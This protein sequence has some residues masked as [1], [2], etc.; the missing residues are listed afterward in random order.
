MK[1][2]EYDE[3]ITISIIEHTDY[4]GDTSIN[5]KTQ[6]ARIGPKLR[7]LGFDFDKSIR[8]F[9]HPNLD[10]KNIIN[11]RYW[12]KSQKTYMKEIIITNLYT[13]SHKNTSCRIKYDFE[14][15]ING[16]IITW[17]FA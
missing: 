10:L 9:K 3:N 1:S 4:F 11:W 12:A 2:F 7:K 17:E 5:L 6:Y 15:K 13:Y 16:E 8:I 14:L